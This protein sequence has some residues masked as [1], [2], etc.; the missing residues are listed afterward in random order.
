M[1]EYVSANGIDIVLVLVM[2][3]MTVLGLKIWPII[4]SNK[5]WQAEME[6]RVSVVELRM[7][8]E[9]DAIDRERSDRAAALRDMQVLLK[10]IQHTLTDIKSRLAVLEERSRLKDGRSGS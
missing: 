4:N 10:E 6:R 1:Q 9:N 2:G 5:A 3:F 8:N 7:N